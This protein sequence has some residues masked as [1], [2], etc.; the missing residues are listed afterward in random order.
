MTNGRY[1]G[2]KALRP[3]S[4]RDV[5]QRCPLARARRVRQAR[6]C[7]WGTEKL[8]CRRNAHAEQLLRGAAAARQRRPALRSAFST[9]ACSSRCARACCLSSRQCCVCFTQN[10]TRRVNVRRTLL[11]RA[12]VTQR[13]RPPMSGECGCVSGTSSAP[14]CVEQRARSAAAA[15]SRRRTRS[16]NPRS[17]RTLSLRDMQLAR[18]WRGAHG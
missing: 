1:A 15:A 9:Q 12:G 2:Q 8:R 7:A 4:Q 16:P 18:A 6:A 5:A 11:L 13:T 14:L 3:A 10:V 17:R